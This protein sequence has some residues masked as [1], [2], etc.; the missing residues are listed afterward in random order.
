MASQPLQAFIRCAWHT[1]PPGAFRSNIDPEVSMQPGLTIFDCDGVLVDSEVIAC[2]IC[3]LSLAELGI[4]TTAEEIADRYIGSSARAMIADLEILHGQPL[5]VD[6][7]DT[8]RDRIEAAFESDA[9]RIDGVD[10]VLASHLGKICVASGSTPERVRH[11]LTLVGLLDYFD[12]HIFS[13]TQVARAKPAPDLFLYASQQMDADARDCLVIEDSVLGVT[14]AIAA[15]MRVIGFIGASHCRPG[16][17][18]RL[19]AAGASAIFQH[20]RE[21]PGLF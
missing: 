6:F 14:A 9:L 16:H 19:L 17:A 15:G 18:D 1:C 4:I 13:A 2:R 8:L 10:A 3:A 5:P 11:C 21:L 12:P 7:Y 20:M